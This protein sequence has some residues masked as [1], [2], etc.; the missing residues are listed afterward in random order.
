MFEILKKYV[1]DDPEQDDVWENKHAFFRI[2]EGELEETEEALGRDLPL[3][4]KTFYEEVG[5]G[6]LCIGEG[7]NVNRII[8]AI[9]IADFVEGIND[10]ENDPRREYYNESDKMVFFEVSSDVFIVLDLE[11]E[12]SH[13][14]CPL[15]YFNKK[16]ANNIEEFIIKMDLEPNYYID[17][18]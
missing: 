17:S 5:Y 8:S 14:Q 11:Q 13:G 9:E 6:F 15:Y 12:N 2:D 10:Y 4:L 3:E 16:I 1:F 7:N 18:L